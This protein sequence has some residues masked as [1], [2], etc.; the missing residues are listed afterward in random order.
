MRVAWTQP[1][2]VPVSYNT[3]DGSA[4]AGSD[5]FSSN[6]V[7]TLPIDQR[8]RLFPITIVD[9]NLEEESETFEF[10]LALPPSVRE[11]ITWTN[12][13]V[14]SITINDNEALNPP[15][16][17]LATST[18][19]TWIGL[20]WS[21]PEN[22]PS[23]FLGYQ[24]EVSEN[25]NSGWSAL[26]ENYPL[27]SYS[28]ADLE[29]QS[30]RY[31][32]VA[33][34]DPSRLSAFSSVVNTS[35]SEIGV[36][37]IKLQHGKNTDTL[38]SG[39]V[40]V[41]T[42]VETVNSA[43]VVS[44]KKS[45]CNH[46]WSLEEGSAVCRQLGYPGVFETTL[47]SHFGEYLPAYFILKNFACTGEEA[48]LVDCP[49]E[50][51]ASTCHFSERGGVICQK[52]AG[53]PV[54]TIE[55]DS[56]LIVEG[57][58]TNFVLTRTGGEL[59]RRFTVNLSVSDTSQSIR[60]SAPTKATF[61]ASESTVILGIATTDDSVVQQSRTI[62][63]KLATDNGYTLYKLGTP[64]TAE[65]TVID[66]DGDTLPPPTNVSA[67]S[68]E[69]TWIGLSWSTPENL[70]SDFLGYQVEVSENGTSGWSALA[71]NYPLTSYSHADLEVQS[72]RY[73]RV[74]SVYSS[75]LSIFSSVVNTSTSEIGVNNIK[76]Q[77]GKNTDTLASGDVDVV[78][79]VETVNSASI[80][81]EKKSICNHGWSLEEGSV[82]CRQLGYP[83]VFETTLRSH[84]GEYLPAYF[85]LKNFA[86]TG[87][88][89]RLVDCPGE[90]RASTC[91]FSER[92]GVICQKEAGI[93]VITIEASSSSVTEGGGAAF[94]L[95]R[96]GGNLARTFTVN[97]S[98][99]ETAQMISGSTSTTV[100]FRASEAIVI[101]NVATEDD[102]IPE[103]NSTIRVSLAE[104]NG[105]TL[106]KL[107]S[108]SEAE[109]RVLDND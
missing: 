87:E 21:A 45:I 69:P 6:G 76:L 98:I 72:M 60:G 52:E 23:D 84:F 56:L 18:E 50:D 71:E 30:T 39:D 70:P 47:R 85:V 108:S 16:N 68:T 27:T 19:P 77:H 33:S 63:V 7:L 59:T 54:I 32:R 74:A 99:S 42:A 51:R 95:T 13:G 43:S 29:A 80:V 55:A 105:Y 11:R 83:G 25:G 22:L 40:D 82:V 1:V 20:S 46:G 103:Q 96:I 3:R 34:V 9:D 64:S 88:E 26:V 89:A 57:S 44:E 24:V 75:G 104:D 28:H 93:P 81:S 62:R 79:A 15:T 37:N 58:S 12:G 8:E 5:Y 86:C 92:G 65:Q 2:A 35:T 100:T 67:T 36:N 49:G 17:V 91:H 14:G 78:T 94:T 73:Y 48:R 66:N 106:Y 4:K 90:D 102:F 61:A 101:F 109:K 38:A 41:V 107:G 10:V 97:L 31:Y 53:I